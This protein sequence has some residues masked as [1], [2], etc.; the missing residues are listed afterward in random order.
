MLGVHTLTCDTSCFRGLLQVT[1][2]DVGLFDFAGLDAAPFLLLACLLIALADLSC[3]LIHTVLYSTVFPL[4]CIS[5]HRVFVLL[6]FLIYLCGAWLL[7][8][9]VL[10]KDTL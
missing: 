10:K 1:A 8:Q 5:T 6:L 7:E 3:L 4:N 2:W 9:A